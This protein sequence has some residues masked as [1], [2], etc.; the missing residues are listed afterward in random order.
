MKFWAKRYGRELTVKVEELAGALHQ[1]LRQARFGRD[2]VSIEL[3][4]GDY[5]E[6]SSALLSPRAS[7]DW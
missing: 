2:V 3:S 1:V 6:A 4:P 5:H 7:D